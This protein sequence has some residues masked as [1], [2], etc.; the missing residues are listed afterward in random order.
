M[1]LI[2]LII[3]AVLFT[4][5]AVVIQKV[6]GKAL[7]RMMLREEAVKQ[8]V[9]PDIMEAIGYVE[10]KWNLAATN[11]TGPDGARG[12]AY[13]PTQITERTA[14]AHGYE[15][16]M[17]E[18][19]RDARLAAFWTAKIMRARPGGPP[20][21]IEDAGAWWNAGRKSASLLTDTHVTR[22]VYIPR[23]VA[24]LRMVQADGSQG[25]A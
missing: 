3:F 25:V 22:V 14:R 19:T 7:V 13:G 21:T 10:S 23:A 12:G 9:D 18:L 24:A 1:P 5:G 17:I 8:N 2:T 4:G 11:L 20:E 16:D 6:G 15:G